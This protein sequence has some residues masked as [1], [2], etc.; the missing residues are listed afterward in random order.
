MVSSS[1]SV[2]HLLI[3]RGLRGDRPALLRPGSFGMAAWAFFLL[4]LF[5]LPMFGQT[6]GSSGTVKGTVLDPSGAIL[7]G[8]VVDLQNPVSGYQRTTTTDEAGRFEF[9]NVPFNPY[10][11]SVSAPSFQAAQQDVTVRTSVPID[12]KLTLAIAT[13]TSQ[14]TIHA[15][16]S[17][18]IEQT[19]VSH[20]DVDS[21]LIA[22]LPIQNPSIGLSEV[23][24][25]A[26]PGVAADAN[27]FFHPLG[28][29][30]E[31]SISLDNQPINDQYSKLFSNQVPLD[32]IQ[33]MEVISGTPQ[34][35]YGDKTSL[36]VNAVTKSGL[37]EAKPHGSFSVQYG[38]FGTTTEDFS[39]GAGGRTWGNFLAANFT[40]SSRFLDTP[41]FMPFHAR[42]NGENL[43]DRI[44]FQPNASDTY[45]LN[46]SLGRSWFQI[47]NNYDQLAAGQDQHQQIRTLNIAPGWTHLFNSTTLLT[48][49]PFFRLD[50]VQ[51]FP[52]GN[53]FSDTPATLSQDRRMAVLGARVD[54]SYSQGI[55]NAKVGGQIQH[56]LLTE[57]FNTGLTDP[58]F[59]PVCLDTEGNPVTDPTLTDPNQCAGAG[60][61]A[62]P[63]LLPG[64][65][66]FDLTRGGSLFDFHD[67]GDI[68]EVGF[69]GQ[70]SLKL[71]NLTLNLGVRGDVYRGLSRANQIEPRVGIA[72]LLKATTTVLRVSYGRFLETPYNENLLL[73]SATGGGG[74]ATNVFGAFEAV[75]LKPGRRNQFN[76]GFQQP[77]G[78]WIVVDADYFW[79]YTQNAYDFD[80]LFDTPLAF[81]IEWRKSK[82]DGLGIRVNLTRIHGLTAYSVMGHARSRFFG[83]ENGGLIFNSPLNVDVFRID[84]DQAFQQST[85]FQ[86]QFPKHGPWVAFT[87]RYDSGLVAG[88]VPD[89]ATALSLDGD[90]Q[91]AIGFHCGSTYP[92]PNM[93]I[94]ACDVPYP[95]W[96][97]TRLRIPAPGTENDD[98]NPPRIAAR[99]LFNIGVGLDNILHTDRY[100]LN[101]RFTAINLTNKV[102]LYN[103]LSTFSGTHFVTPRVYQGQV[104]V[105]F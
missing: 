27:G 79:R 101:L 93:P 104:E 16:S 66:P 69:Y 59:N 60:Y 8:A 31:A 26:S 95:Q 45:H 50:H 12:L 7:R 30:A 48:F 58:T 22:K 55:H 11:L 35:E 68:K 29:H 20:T 92:T 61:G 36:V 86:Y 2:R 4:S 24:T 75:P 10:H 71:R 53:P 96:G 91:V 3:H 34:A 39:L 87:W 33:S 43:F 72:Y 49:N 1:V 40:N 90:Q 17:G 47:P 77:I 84:H 42:G 81:P 97:A 80:V 82:I 38:S 78:C 32:A 28:D 74:L 62:S 56:H 25:N 21:S 63:N 88:A 46:L 85:H 94:S 70:D 15:E 5:A 6:L 99:D 37:G 76:A 23:L 57:S 13:A 103:F 44:D 83:P 14:V 89:L 98:T 19:P 41:E 67:T 9:T 100:K 18:L 102:A 105:A 73:S 65:V 64:L 51:Y 52:S 54:L